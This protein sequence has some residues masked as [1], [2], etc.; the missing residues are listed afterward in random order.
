MTLSRS[1]A[2]NKKSLYLDDRP[3]VKDEFNYDQI[4]HSLKEVIKQ[5][6][7]FPTHISLMGEWGSGKSTVLKLLTESLK[8]ERRIAIKEFS[9]WKYSDDTTTLQRRIIRQVK[10]ELKSDAKKQTEK[11]FPQK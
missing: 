10:Q 2:E 6:D 3:T 1:P 11:D 4:A 5:Q 7:D 8:E 9:V